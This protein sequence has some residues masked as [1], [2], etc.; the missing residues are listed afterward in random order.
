MLK[1][2]NHKTVVTMTTWCDD[3]QNRDKTRFGLACELTRRAIQDGHIVVIAD[4]SKN[5]YVPTEL[6]KIGANVLLQSGESM[7]E[8]R[9]RLWKRAQ[10]FVTSDV[11]AILWTEEKPDLISYIPAMVTRMKEQDAAVLIPSRS[12]DSWDSY[13]KF[14]Q[15]TE[16]TA[17]SVYNYLFPGEDGEQLDPMFGPVCFSPETLHYCYDFDPISYGLP[18]TYIQHFVPVFMKSQGHKVTSI[19]VEYRYPPEQ[20]TEEESTKLKEMVEKRGWQL[21]QLVDAHLTMHQ[22]FF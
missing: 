11:A 12:D 22:K 16:R 8:E 10:E 5:D 14:Q 20:K 1:P 17:N 2:D 7:G 13:P 9:R 15:E 19:N 4:G 6:E 3:P 21:R 18:D